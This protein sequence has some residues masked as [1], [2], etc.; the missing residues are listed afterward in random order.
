MEN[1]RT[2]ITGVVTGLCSAKNAREQKEVLQRYFADDAAFDHPMCA[3]VSYPGVRCVCLTQSRDTGLLPI[4]QWL[5]IMFQDTMIQVHDIGMD[6][7][8]NRMFLRITQKLRA[9]VWAIRKVYA[10]TVEYVHKLTQ[11][12]GDA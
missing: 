8:T 5:R 9:N 6:Q 12:R 10:P 1:P 3:V 4:Y 2:E 11:N 7:E